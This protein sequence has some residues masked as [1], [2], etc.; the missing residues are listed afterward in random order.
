MK[1]FK[2]DVCRVFKANETNTGAFST[3]TLA[4]G[5]EYIISGLALLHQQNPN[6][7]E[8]YLGTGTRRGIDVKIW[9]FCN[10]NSMLKATQ[11]ITYYIS[12]KT[13]SQDA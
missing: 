9:G 13:L 12:G 1:Y 3:V 2:G 8:V 5:T 6:Q 7:K 10:Y 11:K 4:N